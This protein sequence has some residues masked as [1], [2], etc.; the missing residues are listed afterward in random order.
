M[1]QHAIIALV[2]GGLAGG[3]LSILLGVLAH[4]SPFGVLGE[5]P[6]EVA[7]RLK[8]K[9]VELNARL[10][11]LAPAAPDVAP[12]AASAASPTAET[13]QAA[14]QALKKLE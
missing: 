11:A 1:F 7:E 13:R 3:R 14:Q 4:L 8:V 5:L 6:G 12:G 9:I 10:Q 2:E